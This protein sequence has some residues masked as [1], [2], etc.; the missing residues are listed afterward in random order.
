MA[1]VN[2]LATGVD[3][4]PESAAQTALCGGDH[5]RLELVRRLAGS[6]L[7]LALSLPFAL[8]RVPNVLVV[9]VVLHEVH[10]NATGVVAAAML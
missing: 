8:I 3:D 2:Q 5:R 10:G 6:A 7:L 4:A 9:P 1:P